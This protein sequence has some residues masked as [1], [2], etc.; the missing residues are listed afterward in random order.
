MLCL[1]TGA[2]AQAQDRLCDPGGEDCRSL[3]RDRIQNESVGIDVAFWFMEDARYT[4]DL[5]RAWQRN[6]RVRVIV[7]SRANATYPENINRLAELRN[8]GIPMRERF[9]PGI[10][11]WKMMLFEAQ[12]V[13][14]FSGANYS[15]N[16]WVPSAGTAPFT[17]YTDESIFFTP[18]ASIVNSFRTKFDDLWMNSTEYRDY[19]N[20]PPTRTRAYDTFPKDPELN[21]SPSQSYANRA[22]SR[23]NAE[24]V[25]IDVI[26]YRITDQRHANAMIAARNRGL[27]VR[28]ITEPKQYRDV[29][30][31][32]HSWNVD[33][34]YMAGVQIKERAHLGLNHQK[35]VLLRG[36]AMTIFGSSNWS[37]A[38]SESQEEHNL[39]TVDP[40]IYTWFDAQFARKWDNLAGVVENVPFVPKGPDAPKTPAPANL[41]TNLRTDASLALRWYGGPWAH[42]YD[43]YLG[44]D[45]ASLPL[46]AENLALGPSESLT[47]MQQHVVSAGALTPGTTY[48]WKVVGKTMA[49]RQTSSAVWSFTTAGVAPTATIVREPYLQQVSATGAVIVWATREAGPAEARFATGG[50][51]PVSAPAVTTLLTAAT[52]RM[53]SDYYQHV[54]TL[55][56]LSPSTQYQYDILVSGIDVNPVADTFRTAPAH[57]TGAATFIA[58]GD[59]GTGST[60]QRDLASVMANDTFDF[61]L[62]SG[63]VAYGVSTGTG[64]ATFETTNSWFFDIY[65][66]WLRAK[67][68]FPV[69]GNHDSRSENDNGVPY[70]SLFELP[71]NGGSETY[72]A[73]AE[74]Y[75]SFDYGPVHVV[76]LDTEFAFLDA[77]RRAAQLAW[78]EQDLASTSQPWKIAVFH[79]SP[80]SAGGE[81]GSALDVR[82]AFAPIFERQGVQLAIS[83]H[84]HDYERSV[85]LIADTA[86]DGGVT[87]VVTGGGGGPLYPASRGSW[88]AASASRYHYVRASATEC[89]LRLDAVATDRSIFDTFSASRCTPPADT[90]P[91]AVSITAPA[92]GTVVKGVATVTVG[93]TDNVGIAY[94]QLFVDGV[95][96]GRDPTAP[97]SFIWDSAT[98]P[99]GTRTLRATATDAAGNTTTSSGISVTVSNSTGGSGDIVL[100]TGDAATRI[101]GTQWVRE[102]DPTAAGGVRLRDKDAGLARPTTALAAPG[103]YF[104]ITFVAPAGVPYHLWLRGKADANSWGND[105]VFVQFSDVTGSLIDT[106]G[107]AE[108]N[109]EDC[110]GCRV[111][112]WGWQ[113]NGYGSG[114]LGPDLVFTRPGEHTLRIQTREDGLSIDQIILSP[115]EFRTRAPGPLMND[116]NIYRRST[117]VEVPADTVA[118]VASITSPAAGAT[119]TGTVNVSVQASDNVGV[120]RVEILLDDRPPFAAVTSAPYSF[121]WNTGSVLNGSYAL[122]ARAFDAANNVTTTAAVTVVVD[123]P[124]PADTV[125]PTATITSP[126]AGQTVS[127]TAVVTATASDAVGV[128]HVKWFIDGSE[129]TPFSTSSPYSFSWE[130]TGLVDGPHTVRA[131]AV[132]AAGNVGDSLTV[133]VTV[134]NMALATPRRIVLHTADTPPAQMFGAWRREVDASAASGA[135]LRHPDAGVPK[136]ANALATPV[137]YFELTFT[138]EA[139]VPYHLWMRARAEPNSWANE[140]VFVQ[141]SNVTGAAVGTTGYASMNLEDCSGCGVS[142]WGWQDNGYGNIGPDF[143]FTRSGLQTIRVQT[144]EDGVAID[145]I[146]LDPLPS[147]TTAPGP[148]KND[149]TILQKTASQ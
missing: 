57:G 124:P 38:S 123:N 66:N 10:L 52:T 60:A 77:G 74:R 26:M 133:S 63:D 73:H 7:D 62:H 27:P 1:A 54:A 39:F 18:K 128:T 89:T 25:G 46:V 32:W 45:S 71:R 140:S 40:G 70:L 125:A 85:P 98:D 147:R 5:I 92:P 149:N 43:V 118:P 141:F 86:A 4:A 72:P 13:V 114:V 2:P 53:A 3:L 119:L 139:N 93:A 76:A 42:L 75:Y 142:G 97:Y 78:L 64:A 132:D 8:A 81:H 31:L 58:F 20:V 94:T 69:M 44:T 112:G 129:V 145:Q 80:Y 122:R 101:V 79:R 126:V 116:A 84:E 30:K 37:S 34:L 107:A 135:R 109:L 6:V 11:H 127:G 131:R 130:T 22:V 51:V 100:Y 136:R 29:A 59:S 83:G 103:D 117:G 146:V 61:A 41:A 82:A 105:S 99:N 87:Y 106:T 49:A 115:A 33:R 91:P 90:T 148:L 121:V 23:Y 35:S 24:P 55:T 28:L 12:G 113:D 48:F 102:A 104:E 95:A 36:Q 9:A 134:A 143:V 111:A 16:A 15:D 108:V 21:F 68:A 19:A 67:A 96:V 120:T 144:R 65:R 138:A 88:T 47:Q 14:E 110:N 50:G 137:D 56:G 17:N